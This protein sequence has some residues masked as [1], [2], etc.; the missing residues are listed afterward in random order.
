MHRGVQNTHFHILDDIRTILLT[1]AAAA[2][3]PT[4][5]ADLQR[6]DI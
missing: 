6:T 2:L 1:R 5:I 4:Q 3:S